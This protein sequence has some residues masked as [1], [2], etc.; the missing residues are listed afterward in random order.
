M[1][2]SRR[3]LPIKENFTPPTNFLIYNYLTNHSVSVSSEN[4]LGRETVLV[5][6]IQSLKT[7]GLSSEEVA[8]YLPP[9]NNIKIYIIDPKTKEKKLYSTVVIDLDPLERI[10]NL[11]IGMITTRFIGSTDS[12]RMSTTSGN[13]IGGNAWVKIHNV[14]DLPLRLN[15]DVVIP[16]HDTYRYLGYLNQGITL[17]TIFHDVDGIYPDY[18]YL[19]PYSD[20]Y[21]G[22]VSDLR[23]PLD[24][25][26]Q[27]EYND[28]CDYGQTMWPFQEG[29]L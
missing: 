1:S 14:T 9:G 2:R 21:Y 29:V 11:H 3:D 13:A 17:G 12:L 28:R 4:K 23:Q 5:P 27:L 19:R 8:R 7:K 24:G 22:I 18:Q 6:E 20:L 26:W 25:C 16:P 15:D 10:K